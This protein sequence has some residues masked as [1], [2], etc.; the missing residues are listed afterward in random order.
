MPACGRDGPEPAGAVFELTN[1]SEARNHGRSEADAYVL[2]RPQY[3][4]VCL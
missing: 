1:G 2:P 3:A 4:P